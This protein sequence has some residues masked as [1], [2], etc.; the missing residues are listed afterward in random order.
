MRIP[1]STYRLQLHKDFGFRAVKEIV[2]YLRELGIS[3]VYASPIFKARKGSLHGYDVVNPGE[4]N[5]ELGD[6]AD[7]EDLAQE[8]KK[9]DM[10]WPHFLEGST[11]NPWNKAWS[12][13]NKTKKKNVRGLDVPDRND[14]YLPFEADGLFRDHVIAFARKREGKWA[15]TV[16]PRFF[17]ALTGAGNHPL[18]EET[19]QDTKVLFPQEAQQRLKNALTGEKIAGRGGIRVAEILRTFPVALPTSEEPS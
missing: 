1:V 9:H 4:L 12:R 7:F 16:A 15:V 18:G 10:G 17:F 3:D 19:W 6:A 13:I 8:I 14:D 11:A 2:S 5:P